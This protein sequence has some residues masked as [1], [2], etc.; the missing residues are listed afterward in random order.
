MGYG[1]QDKKVS[2]DLAEVTKN[3]QALAELGS[4]CLADEKFIRYK[5][6]YITVRERLIN[7]MLSTSNPDPVSDAFFLRTCLA[8]IDTLKMMID[9]I[10]KDA[11]RRIK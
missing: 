1:E 7:L 6:Q 9:V 11:S 2:K 5:E 8:K 10:E 4:K 3:I